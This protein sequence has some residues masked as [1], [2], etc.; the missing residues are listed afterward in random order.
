MSGVFLLI[1]VVGATLA[2]SLWHWDG[3]LEHSWFL[4]DKAAHVATFLLLTFWYTGQ[5]RRS[6][7]PVIALSLLSF[8]ALIEICQYLVGYRSAE[9]A[10]LLADAAGIG[11]GVLMAMLVTGGWSLRAEA[12]LIRRYG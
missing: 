12:Y 10:D 1:G 5:Y 4:S 8:G 11:A 9:W 7:Y 3:R 6:L 2:P